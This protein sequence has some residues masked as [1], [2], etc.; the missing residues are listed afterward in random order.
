MSLLKSP[1]VGSALWRRHPFDVPVE[2]EEVAAVLVAGAGDASASGDISALGG[3]QMAWGPDVTAVVAVIGGASDDVTPRPIFVVGKIDGACPLG[4]GGQSGGFEYLAAFGVGSAAEVPAVDDEADGLFFVGVTWAAI[5][6]DAAVVVIDGSLGQERDE[7]LKPRLFGL[8][9]GAA[10]DL[11]I[12]VFGVEICT[13]AD[14]ADV[15]SADDV[16]TLFAR[17]SQGGDKNAHQQRDDSDYDQKLNER[18]CPATVHCRDLM[19]NLPSGR[20]VHFHF[21]VI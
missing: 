13:Q 4:A 17:L 12:V 1:Q 14:L 7:E 18:E 9:G 21:R 6:F 19:L 5:D 10:R 8:T 16:F 11:K 15:T 20:T 3:R 2:K